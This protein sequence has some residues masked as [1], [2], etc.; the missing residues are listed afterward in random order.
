MSYRPEEKYHGCLPIG[1][2]TKHFIVSFDTPRHY[3][4]SKLL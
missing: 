2:I 3:K 4:E 1:P